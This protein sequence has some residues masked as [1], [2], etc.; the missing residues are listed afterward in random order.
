M[1]DT[2][3]DETR[4]AGIDTCP[5]SLDTSPTCLDTCPTCGSRVRIVGTTIMYYE[6]IEENLA[7]QMEI[8]ELRAV[9]DSMKRIE[10][11]STWSMV[12]VSVSTAP[13]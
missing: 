9:V 10:A 3:D 8:A 4:N 2:Q 5:T 11:S 1:S 7:L 12:T 13:S 6:P